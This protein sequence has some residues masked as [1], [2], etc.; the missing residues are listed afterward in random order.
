VEIP[1]DD[2]FYLVAVSMLEIPELCDE[3]IVVTVLP[4]DQSDVDVPG[5]KRFQYF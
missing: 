2:P 3:E 5:Q 4:D 1:F